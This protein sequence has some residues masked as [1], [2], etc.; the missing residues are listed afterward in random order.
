MTNLTI[1]IL[2]SREEVKM[3]SY[4]KVIP[5]VSLV[6]TGNALLNFIAV[7]VNVSLLHLALHLSHSPPTSGGRGPL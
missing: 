2:Q 7:S 4:M 1:V 6:I 3:Q 5:N